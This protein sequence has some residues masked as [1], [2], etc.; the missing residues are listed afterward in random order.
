MDE[1]CLLSERTCII[2]HAAESF[3]RQAHFF[4]TSAVFAFC[5]KTGH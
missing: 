1:R 2:L 4:K 3:S 5:I